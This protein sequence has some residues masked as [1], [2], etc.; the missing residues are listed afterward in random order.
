MPKKKHEPKTVRLAV[1]RTIHQRNH[2][3][4]VYVVEKRA[5][6]WILGANGEWFSPTN[7]MWSSDM[8]TRPWDGNSIAPGTLCKAQNWR[9]KKNIP[10]IVLS[11]SGRT[12]TY[13]VMQGS[14]TFEISDTAIVPI[15][16]AES[17][18]SSGEQQ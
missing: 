12:R 4:T 9:L 1:V 14:E 5:D 3:M 2:F 18:P 16:V 11:W 6:G 7:V 8:E 15:E 17:A 13:T 10:V